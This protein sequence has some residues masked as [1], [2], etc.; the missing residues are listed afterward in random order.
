[1]D[2]IN[3]LAW[4]FV[5][6][7]VLGMII[8]VVWPICVDIFLLYLNK[9]KNYFRH[10][11]ALLEITDIRSGKVSAPRMTEHEEQADGCMIVRTLENGVL[12]KKERFTP[13]EWK[14]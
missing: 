6:C 14:E 4:F 8:Y 11:R 1:M 7:I 2:W 9:V 13:W 5:G 10:R 3:K 12:V